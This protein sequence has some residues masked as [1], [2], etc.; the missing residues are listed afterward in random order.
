MLDLFSGDFYRAEAT[1]AAVIVGL[2]YG[3]FSPVIWPSVL[4]ANPVSN[5]FNITCV[6]SFPN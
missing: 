4:P 5:T 1:V 6:S 2:E 3:I